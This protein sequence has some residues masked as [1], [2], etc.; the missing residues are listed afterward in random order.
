MAAGENLRAPDSGTVPP[1][2]QVGL[3]GRRVGERKSE[4]KKRPKSN[5]TGLKLII[6]TRK[7][8]IYKGR[9]I[10]MMRKKRKPRQRRC[11]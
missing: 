7:K 11:F 9:E 10:G 8:D 6:L 1:L 4:I 3:S 2:G 5:L